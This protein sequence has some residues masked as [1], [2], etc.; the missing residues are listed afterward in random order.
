MKI[1]TIISVFKVH[2]I[3]QTFEELQQLGLLL[4]GTDFFNK[5]FLQV[6]FTRMGTRSFLSCNYYTMNS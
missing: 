4:A 3:L 2:I 6:G 1:V 5:V